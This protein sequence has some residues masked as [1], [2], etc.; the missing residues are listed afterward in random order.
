[1][2]VQAVFALTIVLLPAYTA[3]LYGGTK[4]FGLAKETTFRLICY[5]LIGAS[6]IIGMPLLDGILR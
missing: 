2:F 5:L 6:A 1:L 4:L 3:G